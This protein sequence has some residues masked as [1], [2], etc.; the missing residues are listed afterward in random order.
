MPV[1]IVQRRKALQPVWVPLPD[2]EEVLPEVPAEQQPKEDFESWTE[3]YRRSA[4][5]SLALAVKRWQ[6]PEPWASLARGTVAFLDQAGVAVLGVADLLRALVTRPGKTLGSIWQG[7]TQ[8]P[9]IFGDVLQVGMGHAL[10]SAGIVPTSTVLQDYER[11]KSRIF[12]VGELV[13]DRVTARDAAEREKLEALQELY[14]TPEGALGGAVGTLAAL[15]VGSKGIG[16]L[17][18]GSRTALQVARAAPRRAFLRGL[19]SELN[20]QALELGGLTAASIYGQ[21]TGPIIRDEM[22]PGAAMW[23]ALTSGATT[24][25][26]VR[27]FPPL[28]PMPSLGRI[29]TVAAGE[30]AVNTLGTLLAHAPRIA[31]MTA[32]P[33]EY[34]T[35]VQI[36]PFRAP[37]EVVPELIAGIALPP[38]L[39]ALEG[40]QLRG[41]RGVGRQPGQPPRTPPTTAQQPPGGAPP[42]SGLSGAPPAAPQQP[43][44]RGYSATTSTVVGTTSSTSTPSRR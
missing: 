7:I 43:G 42:A 6:L 39:R 13:E 20:R 35:A 22:E 17:G 29:A 38:A 5:A 2:L 41:V 3:Q 32:K 25:I 14:G 23:E 12:G 33:E 36:G 9:S 28:R 30:A 44:T 26:G 34:P 31:L 27:M 24:A 21:Y 10:A 37:S 16:A 19:T 1:I 15:L 4:A 18:R 8:L 40:V 11:L